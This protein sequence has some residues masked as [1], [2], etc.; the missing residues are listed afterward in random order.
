MQLIFEASS[1]KEAKCFY[2]VLGKL[3]LGMILAS[4]FIALLSVSV[5]NGVEAFKIYTTVKPRCVI[6]GCI[7]Q[8]HL[9]VSVVPEKESLFYRSPQLSFPRIILLLLDPPTNTFNRGLTVYKR[10]FLLR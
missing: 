2:I 9:P 7:V 1:I 3:G 5:K 6:P 10:L 8:L 4:V